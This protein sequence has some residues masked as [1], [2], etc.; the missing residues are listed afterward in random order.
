MPS[1]GTP[2]SHHVHAVLLDVGRLATYVVLPVPV[3]NT[4]VAA[5]HSKV[6]PV[7]SVLGLAL[8][9]LMLEMVVVVA[10]D[11]L[12]LVIVC[13]AVTADGVSNRASDYAGASQS[14]AIL[15]RPQDSLSRGLA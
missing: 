15:R 13:S 7:A 14:V 6:Y 3:Q 2:S 10:G 5:F 11:G 12:A 8:L 9:L 4:A 1:L